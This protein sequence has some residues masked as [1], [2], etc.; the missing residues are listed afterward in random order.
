M[1]NQLLTHYLMRSAEGDQ[2]AFRSLAEYLG[3]KIFALAYRF[4][5]GERA[6]AEDVTQDVLMKLWQFAP[7][8]QPGGSVQGWASKLTYHAC[9]DVYRA[10]KN[11]NDELPE[12]L[13][14]PET[15][16]DQVLSNEYRTL[17]FA[18]LGRLPERQK[19]ALL[20]VYFHEN[21][22]REAAAAME[23]TEK[24]LEH[25]IARGLKA[26]SQLIPAN[27]NGEKHDLAAQKL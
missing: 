13:A 8:W 27:I 4:L 12:D 5:N 3:Q 20:L 16:T 22:R 15:A 11:R 17:L 10:R 23:T 14:I 18:A 1:D 24:A 25:L 9:M 19:E 7:K 6:M 26:L 21:S 2:S